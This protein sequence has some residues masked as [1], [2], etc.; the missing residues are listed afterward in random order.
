M[1]LLFFGDLYLYPY[2]SYTHIG[3]NSRSPKVDLLFGSAQGVGNAAGPVP[4]AFTA[5]G[6]RDA[7]RRPGLQEEAA[8]ADS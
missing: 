1:D 6:L 8:G 4:D 5:A 3:L 2:G 7:T